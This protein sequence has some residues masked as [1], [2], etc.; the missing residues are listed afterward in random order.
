MYLK[1]LL[2]ESINAHQ[3]RFLGL[4]ILSLGNGRLGLQLLRL[5]HIKRQPIIVRVGLDQNIDNTLE[6]L[7][8]EITVSL[9]RV[10]II[11]SVLG[12]LS[13]VLIDV[14]NFVSLQR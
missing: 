4:R 2:P 1:I 6:G 9:K 8:G 3:F 12:L 11:G 10:D 5:A 13:R 14:S 7:K